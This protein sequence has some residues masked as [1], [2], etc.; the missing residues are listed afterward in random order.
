MFGRARAPEG[1]FETV[2]LMT[3]YPLG[4]L[5]NF[6]HTSCMYAHPWAFSESKGDLMVTWSE[7]GPE[8]NVVAIKIRFEQ[9]IGRAQ[10]PELQIGQSIHEESDDVTSS[11]EERRKRI[12]DKYS[13]EAYEEAGVQSISASS[14]G[15]GVFGKAAAAFAKLSCTSDAA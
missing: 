12:E 9:G 10:P 8:G 4:H 7:G 1:P 2:E 6:K 3:A 11:E 15:K 13:L 14:K 5:K